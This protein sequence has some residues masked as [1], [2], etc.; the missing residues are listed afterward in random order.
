MKN[1]PVAV[2]SERKIQIIVWTLLLCNP[3]IGMAV[4]LIAPSLPAIA[5]NLHV[6]PS[7]AKIVISI[8]LLGYAL[9]NFFTGFLADALGRQKL[10]RIGFLGFVLASLAPAVFPS[11]QVLLIARFLQGVTIGMVAVVARAV[12]SDILPPEKLIRLGPLL[13][14]MWGIGPV[15]G[16]AIGGYLQFYFGWQAGFWFFAIVSLILF[17][18]IFIVVPETHFHR[19]PLHFKT[20]QKNLMEVL[21]HRIFLA[22][23][24]I[25]GLTYSLIIVF[26]TV[27]PFL[28]QTE[29]HHTPV[30][31]G[32]LALCL[33]LVFLLSTILCRFLLKQFKTEQLFL[34][35]ISILVI[36]ALMLVIVSY[37]FPQN[38]T[39]IAVGSALMFFGTG[40]IF[41][42]AMGKGMS[43]FRHIAG[44]ANAVMFLVNVLLTSI[45]SFLISFVTMHSAVPLMWIYFI[46]ILMCTVIYW[47]LINSKG[48]YDANL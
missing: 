8:Y 42:M 40:F 3:L 27:G 9:G 22:L 4:D 15:I 18:A 36:L 32:H 38:I 17:I 19:H 39:L 12:Y 28:I 43:L 16:P 10:L 14:M 21:R 44:T 35:V 13:A 23:I 41:P 48:H 7:V 26:N 1:N 2:L 34:I 47:R 6:L 29:F 46:L 5:V 33:G 30:F 25:M 31:F 37:F 45:S 11:I 24:T 20:M